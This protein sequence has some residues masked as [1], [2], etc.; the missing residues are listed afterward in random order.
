[1]VQG[2]HLKNIGLKNIDFKKK[3]KIFI[4]HERQNHSLVLVPSSKLLRLLYC[5]SNRSPELLNSEPAFDSLL[6]Q[7]L[8]LNWE[9]EYEQVNTGS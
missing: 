4:N 7:L 5:V 6:F 8:E 9:L 2:Q 1:V 3:I